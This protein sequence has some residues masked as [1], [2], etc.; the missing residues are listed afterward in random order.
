MTATLNR[1]IMAPWLTALIQELNGQT[2]PRLRRIHP[3]LT[4]REIFLMLIECQK[5]GT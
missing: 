4:I 1:E 3:D 5:A 2:G